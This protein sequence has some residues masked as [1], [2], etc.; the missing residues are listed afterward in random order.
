MKV[1]AWFRDRAVRRV[2]KF[3]VPV[4]LGRVFVSVAGI[5]TMAML[6]R[7]L[8]VE[9]FG[10][11]AVMR[12]LVATVEVYS[13]FV[14]WQ[15]IIKYG[16]EAI[17]A[18]R[19]DDVKRIIKL[20]FVLDAATAAVATVVIAVLAFA[21]ADAFDWDS[22]ASQLCVLYALT[23]LTRIGGTPDGIFR[24]CDAYRAQAIATSISAVVLTGSV[25][26][27]VLL[28]ASFTQ[29]VIAM[30]AGE[31]IGNLIPFIAAQTVAKEHGFDGWLDRKSVV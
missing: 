24:I 2:V 18:G 28:D 11:L 5:A 23:I 21:L 15:A 29:C 13:N 1:A 20:A 19:K 9:V 17:A 8:G 26:L 31:V 25:A 3:G 27:A 4:A 14:T 7:H 22:R 10:V 16:T 12:T 30:V 6:T